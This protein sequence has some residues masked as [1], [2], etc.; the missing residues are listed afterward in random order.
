M[1]AFS[2]LRAESLTAASRAAADGAT[3]KAGGID[4]LDRLK[5]RVDAPD[6]V[7]ALLE[8]PDDTARRIGLREDGSLWIGAFATLSQIA[9]HAGVRK[10]LPA[11]A[12][13]A[14]HA[15]SFQIRNRATLGGNLAQHTRCGYYRHASFPCF[16]RGSAACPVRADGAVQDTAGIFG[17][18]ACACAHPSSLA[19]VLAA[20]GGRVT[21]RAAGKDNKPADRELAFGEL[22]A[23]PARGRRSDTVLAPG[24]VLVGVAVTP[25]GPTTATGYAEVRQKAAFD[26]AL[27]SCAV[28]LTKGSDGIASAAV[29]FGSLA[30]TPHRSTEAETA[31]AGRAPSVATYDAAGAKAVEGA[32]PL[33]GN[34]YKRELAKV[35]LRRAAESA[36]S[37]WS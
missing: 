35:V 22:F 32:T 14:G 10:A 4:L 16:K 13:A 20:A 2:Y 1:K 34:V 28:R 18:Q 3:L 31:L 12:E 25:D 5:E 7:V 19:P 8:S 36:A 15:A 17:N 30:P 26:W 37:R 23:P 24:D 33:P 6:A 11:L 9:T 21:V 27:A 29:W